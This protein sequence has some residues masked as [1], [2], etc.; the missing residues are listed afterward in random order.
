MFSAMSVFAAVPQQCDVWLLVCSCRILCFRC[1]SKVRFRFR[2]RVSGLGFGVVSGSGFR[3][4]H[5]GFKV[6]GF[7]VGLRFWF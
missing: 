5:F 6:Y 1:G 7:S 4:Q 2:F 3:I